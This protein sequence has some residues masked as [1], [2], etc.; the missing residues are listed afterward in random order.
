MHLRIVCLHEILEH[1]LRPIILDTQTRVLLL[2]PVGEEAS[3]DDHVAIGWLLLSG[4][5]ILP[6]VVLEW[7][8]VNYPPKVVFF[9]AF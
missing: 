7:I 3:Q 9:D 2:E 5:L 4:R 8:A 1:I 6:E